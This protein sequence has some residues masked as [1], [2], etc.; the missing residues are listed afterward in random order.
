MQTPL[1]TFNVQALRNTR[2][3]EGLRVDD[4]NLP[5]YPSV[6]S[7]GP[8]Q[9][10]EPSF[11]STVVFCGDPAQLAEG[12]AIALRAMGVDQ[13]GPGGDPDA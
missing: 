1:Q 12:F 2:S 3:V 8:S 9:R 13:S 5:K 4:R 7:V 11:G 10:A 6:D